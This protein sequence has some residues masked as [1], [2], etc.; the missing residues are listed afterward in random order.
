MNPAYQLSKHLLFVALLSGCSGVETMSLSMT[1]AK[2]IVNQE[3]W[4]CSAACI[5]K[6]QVEGGREQCVAFG[7]GMAEV[8]QKNYAGTTF[9]PGQ[10]NGNYVSANPTQPN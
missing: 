3:L 5:Q 10:L 7:G 1:R 9:D 8:C 6:I 4:K 2:G